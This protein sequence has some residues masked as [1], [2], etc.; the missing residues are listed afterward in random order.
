MIYILGPCAIESEEMYIE[1]G[2]YLYKL[3]KDLGIKEWYY[4]SS[5]SKENRTSLKGKRG[6]TQELWS[7]LE[8]GIKCFKTIKEELPDIKLTTD[9]H[10]PEEA[11]RLVGL[12]DLLQIPAFL[13][14]Q[15]DMLVEAALSCNKVNVKKGQW[16]SPTQSCK[17]IDKIKETNPDCEAWITD[18]GTFFGYN[19]L[20]LDLGGVEYMKKSWDKVLI[21]STHSTQYTRDGF[22]G[23]NRELAKKYFLSAGIFGFDGIFAECHLNPKEAISDADCQIEL[24]QMEGLIDR[25]QLIQKA[26][27]VDLEHK[28]SM[29][30]GD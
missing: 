15:T 25:Q 23:G 6:H 4:K 7:N 20:V 27:E 13:C 3:M 12:I 26:N 1:T 30:F 10:N 11:D 28:H 29:L 5:Y 2:K 9:F 17:W 21:D 16:V 14:R 24:D 8:Y 19:R 18:R 22:T